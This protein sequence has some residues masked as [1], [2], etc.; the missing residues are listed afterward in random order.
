MQRATETEI[1][2]SGIASTSG[3]EFSSDWGAVAILNYE[4]RK[5]QLLFAYTARFT[6][7]MTLPEVF[8]LDQNGNVLGTP[9]PTQSNPFSIHTLQITKSIK[10][11][12]LAIYLG[13]QNIFDYRQAYSPLIGFNDPNAAP[14]FSDAFDTAYS[15][16]PLHGREFYVG[17]KWNT[18]RRR[19]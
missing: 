16:S 4:W 5:Q 8:D 19:R 12:N 1:D 6:G 2:E 14:G 9:R 15:Y 7:E 10:K 17:L 3:I 11:K 13:V 18:G